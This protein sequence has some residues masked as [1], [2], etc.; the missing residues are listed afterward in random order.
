M[1]SLASHTSDT[2][3]E[4]LYSRQLYVLGHEAMKKMSSSNILLIGLRGL[5]VEIAKNLVLGGVKSVTLYDNNITTI[6]DLGSQFYLN[7][8]DIGKSRAEACISELMD[9]NRNVHLK[10]FNDTLNE[11][12]LKE[13][14]YTL[15]IVTNETLDVQIKINNW[16]RL[17]NIGFIA[18]DTFGVVC[19]TFVDLGNDFTVIDA[20]G[21][22]PLSKLISHV[23]NN[24]PGIVTCIED[25]R[26]GLE[27]GDHVLFEEVEGMSELNGPVSRPVKVINPYSFTIED[28]TNYG[29][30]ECGGRFRQ[31]KL[32]KQIE[33]Q[34]LVTQISHPN[35]LMSA[36]MSK[37]DHDLQLHCF[38]QALSLFRT[39]NGRFPTPG[40]ENVILELTKKVFI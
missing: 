2:I 19:S 32:S 21:E 11:N 16:C 13:G 35:I 24:N 40:E 7:E 26:H 37:F 31:K 30:Y 23:S 12:K 4:S 9:L 8:K 28:T 14:G 6:A 27:T 5:G 1:S 39:E 18:A 38:V 15:V 33:F 36:D 10:L 3:D 34:P 17:L 29:N 22:P 20:T 25:V